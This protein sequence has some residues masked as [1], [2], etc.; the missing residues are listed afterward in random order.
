MDAHLA[1]I[2]PKR[3]PMRPAAAGRAMVDA[4]HAVAP[5]IGDGLALY[6]NVRIG[7]ISHQPAGLGAQGAVAAPHPL[8]RMRHGDPDAA[9]V[10]GSPH[11]TLSGRH[12]S[13]S[14]WITVTVHQ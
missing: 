9:A 2:L 4:D 3:L 11:F 13:L 12:Q 7:I 6:P 8:R 14:K 10:A 1:E 5:H